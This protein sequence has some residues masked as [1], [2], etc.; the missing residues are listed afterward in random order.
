MSFK[1]LIQSISHSIVWHWLA[2]R[3]KASRAWIPMN[4]SV[5]AGMRSSGISGLVSAASMIRSMYTSSHH[6]NRL[7]QLCRSGGEI[8]TPMLV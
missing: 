6:M 2:R 8:H 7:K 5:E 4:M 1:S 3:P